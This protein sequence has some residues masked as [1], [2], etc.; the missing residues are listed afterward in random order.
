M[1][2]T[3]QSLEDLGEQV[4][5]TERAKV[6]SAVGDL[7]DALKGDVKEQIEAKSQALAEAAAPLAQKAYEQAQAAEGA[8]GAG[9]AGHD[10]GAEAADDIVDAEFEE[11]KDDDSQS[12]TG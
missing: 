7:K 12:K 3:E 2:S 8:A 5:P 10:G 6:E 4:E 11:V 9:A 1:H